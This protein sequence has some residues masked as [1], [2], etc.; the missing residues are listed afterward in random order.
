MLV[1]NWQAANWGTNY[2]RLL[3]LKQ[4]FDP[5]NLFIVRQGVGSEFWDDEQACRVN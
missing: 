4:R 5:Q 1:P 2:P 3:Q